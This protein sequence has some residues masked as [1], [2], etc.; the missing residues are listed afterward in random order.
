V[1]LTYLP[2]YLRF[3]I[4]AWLDKHHPLPTDGELPIPSTSGPAKVTIELVDGDEDSE[5]KKRQ[6]AEAEAKRVQNALP[7]WIERS[8]ITGEL[9]AAGAAQIPASKPGGIVIQNDGLTKDGTPSPKKATS[10]ATDDV[11][12]YYAALAAAQAAYANAGQAKASTSA[13]AAE[14]EKETSYDDSTSTQQ[15][16]P[17]SGSGGHSKLVDSGYEEFGDDAFSTVS[18]ASNAV[19]PGYLASASDLPSK[20]ASRLPNL[21]PPSALSSQSLGKRSREPSEDGSQDGK[22]ART[23]ETT[24]VEPL[25]PAAELVD[26]EESGEVGDDPILT[27]AVLFW[28]SL[29]SS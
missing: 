21:R 18:P 29:T 14:K 27:G 6:A 16:S 9:T 4:S 26:I 1:Y 23:Q 7:S 15:G 12:A 28:I 13:T 11:D 3:D 22:K 2:F 19:S 17:S 20:A 24:P 10:S 25:S 8:T 5:A